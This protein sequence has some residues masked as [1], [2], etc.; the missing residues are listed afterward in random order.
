MKARVVQTKFWEDNFVIEL[1]HKEK[2]AFLYFLTNPRVNLIGVYELP[3]RVICFDLSLTES[4]LVGIKNTL[5]SG[6]KIHFI[7]GFVMIRNSQKYNNFLKGSEV[8]RRAFCREMELL[9][10]GVKEYL[11]DNKF[12][13]VLDWLATSS[14]LDSNK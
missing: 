3:D 14:K 8:Q 2:L 1:T 12:E 7:D 10:K 6:N 13:L 5:I 9:P 4:E 11:E